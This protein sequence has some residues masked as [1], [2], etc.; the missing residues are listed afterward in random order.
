M[1]EEKYISTTLDELTDPKTKLQEIIAQQKTLHKADENIVNEFKF[2]NQKDRNGI[3]SVLKVTVNNVQKTFRGEP[4]AKA[5]LSE[6]SAAEQALEWLNKEYK[7][8]WK[9]KSDK[10]ICH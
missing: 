3:A 1:D 10:D 5:Q 2:E 7:L 8:Q 4:E 9:S 6:F